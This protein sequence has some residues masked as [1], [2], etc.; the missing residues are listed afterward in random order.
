MVKKKAIIT[1][2]DIIKEVG[3]ICACNSTLALSQLIERQIRVEAPCLDKIKPHEINKLLLAKSRIVV[4]V[5]AQIL[6][7]IFGQISLIFK[8]KSAFEFVSIFATKAR[9]NWGFMTELGVSAIKEVGNVIVSAYSGAMST[10][11]KVQV[12]PS[13]PVMSSG[14][15]EEV[16]KFGFALPDKKK[17]IYVHTM[18]FKDKAR[19]ISGS[20]FLV[21]DTDVSRQICQEMRKE[22]KRIKEGKYFSRKSR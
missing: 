20:F 22:L 21:L 12:I 8:E 1:E 11:M 4:G 5:H 3:S 15:I 17:S 2:Y 7:G 10:L 14:P 9:K 16:I 6:S 18:I 19:K 13:I